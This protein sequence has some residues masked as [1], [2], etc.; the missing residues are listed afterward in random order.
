MLA[1]WTRSG[2]PLQR[3][4]F[5]WPMSCAPSQRDSRRGKRPVTLHSASPRRAPVRFRVAR[6]GDRSAVRAFLDRLSPSTVQ[7]R[8]LSPA[9][10]LTGLLGDHE[11]KR[12]F[13][14]NEAEHVV[15]LAVDG[16]EIRGI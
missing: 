4:A 16:T 8:F 9:R 7:A 11:L 6:A 13:D 10:S 3:S 2:P 15:V 14:R 12:L 1:S 5:A